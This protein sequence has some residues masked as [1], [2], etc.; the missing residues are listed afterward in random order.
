VHSRDVVHTGD[1]N[2]REIVYIGSVWIK[3]HD[4]LTQTLIEVRHIPGMARN[5][6]YLNT[7]DVDGY[8]RSGSHGF[9]KV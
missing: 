8:K 2:P 9:L 1:N 3:M 5:L 6:I 4:G 7:L